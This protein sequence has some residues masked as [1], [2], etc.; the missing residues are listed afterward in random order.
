MAGVDLCPQ[1]IEAARRNAA[2]AGVVN[3]DFVQGDVTDLELM[4]GRTYDLVSLT[5]AAHHLAGLDTVSRALRGMDRLAS[6]SGI[7]FVLDLAR[8]KS[9][10]LTDRC[11][12]AV[13]ADYRT[14]GLD[15]L[16]DEFHDS[17][18]AAW[19]VAELQSAVPSTS[20]RAW[21]QIVPRGLPLVQVLLGVPAMRNRPLVRPAPVWPED[22]H[23]VPGRMRTDW[24]LLRTALALG[25]HRRIA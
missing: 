19:T 17:I 14:L 16:L 3:V 25:R 8:L 20:R 12:E 9:A 13:A 7:V 23:P 2:R 15:N 4:H 18:R 1:M 10:W 24:R 6:A 22:D 11:V 21:W 5:M